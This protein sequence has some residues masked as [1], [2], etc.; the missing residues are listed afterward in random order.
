MALSTTTVFAPGSLPARAWLDQVLDI[1]KEGLLA[2]ADAPGGAEHG[3]AGARITL[4]NV[5][6][7]IQRNQDILQR[8]RRHPSDELRDRVLGIVEEGFGRAAQELFAFSRR[9]PGLL[10]TLDLLL[11]LGTEAF[12]GHVGDGR[13]YLVRRG[14]V[15]QLTVDHSKDDGAIVFE[16]G[17][18]Q[19]ITREELPDQSGSRR[20][21]RALGLQPRVTVESLCMEL[22]PDDRF[23]LTTAHMHRAIPES[24]LHRHLMA[25]SLDSLGPALIRRAGSS[26]LVGVAAQLGGVGP[27]PTESARHRLALLAPM[28]LFKHLTERELRTVAGVTRPR[29]LA[30]GTRVFSQGDPGTELFLVISGAVRIER[31]GVPIITLGAGTNF[32]EMAMLDEP[33]R[34]ASASAQD[35]TELLVIPRDAFFALLKGNPLLAVKILWNLLLGLSANL[36]RTSAQLAEGY[37]CGEEGGAREG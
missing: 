12:V 37:P 8:F 16:D 22:A 9:R 6:N 33:F 30:S 29:R 19:D 4:D 11:L 15:H 14:L 1:P 34:S 13:V 23:V 17:S 7:H 5:R 35:D 18:A 32:G 26:P 31:D 27:A 28:P 20:F 2:V 25:E 10:I 3:R 21:T 24:V 36:R